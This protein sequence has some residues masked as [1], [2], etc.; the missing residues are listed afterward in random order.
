M[1]ELC[2]VV[3]GLR[4][5]GLRPEFL[6]KYK[7]FAMLRKTFKQQ[8]QTSSVASVEG[9][10]KVES[11]GVESKI[12][13][14]GSVMPKS[15]KPVDIMLRGYTTLQFGTSAASVTA[16]IDV[17]SSVGWSAFA[18]MFDEVRINSLEIARM[19]G[20]TSVFTATAYDPNT[21]TLADASKIDEVISR[22]G[23][24]LKVID[25]VTQTARIRCKPIP[26]A[27]PLLESGPIVTVTTKVRDWFA[28]ADADKYSYGTLLAARTTAALVA[29]ANTDG[30]IY[31]WF[32]SFRVRK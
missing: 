18:T 28:T 6:S 8:P 5:T 31:T 13:P 17:T 25:S 20:S 12:F 9:F 4:S 15:S 23:A 27:N 29:G 21:V 7:N 10:A 3:R 19:T 2:P 14:M 32:L 11:K 22:P 16:T 24:L 1:E 30:V 26:F